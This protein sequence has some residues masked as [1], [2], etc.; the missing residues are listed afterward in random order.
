M[1]SYK[2]DSTIRKTTTD[3]SDSLKVK[4]KTQPGERDSE[5]VAIYVPLLRTGIP[6]DLLNFFTF[7]HKIVRG[8][9]LSKGP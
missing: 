4:I 7:I 5:T 1:I 9:D 2:P 6:K 3:K 8:K